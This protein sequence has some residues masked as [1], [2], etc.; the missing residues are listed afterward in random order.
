MAG[1]PPQ[2]PPIAARLDGIAQT[3]RGALRAFDDLDL[4]SARAQL[5]IAYDTLLAVAERERQGGR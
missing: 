3:L 5:N 2:P 1:Y 4:I